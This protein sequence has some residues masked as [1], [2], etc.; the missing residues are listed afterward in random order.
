MPHQ[1]P[2]KQHQTP[3]TKQINHLHPK[4]LQIALYIQPPITATFLIY[5]DYRKIPNSNIKRPQSHHLCKN[6]WNQ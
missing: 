3:Q 1:K 5:L 6:S 2:K 4:P